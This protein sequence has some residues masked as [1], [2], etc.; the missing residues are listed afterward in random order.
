VTPDGKWIAGGGTG[1]PVLVPVDG[2]ALQPT[3][4]LRRGGRHRWPGPPTGSGI[5]VRWGPPCRASNIVNPLTGA[6]KSWRELHP[7]RMA[8][9]RPT[10]P[11]IMPDGRLYPYGFGLN[12]SDLFVVSGVR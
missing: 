10:A 5:S 2:G 12:F 6:R 9:V 1:G 8:G 3:K 4:G 7:P 11:L